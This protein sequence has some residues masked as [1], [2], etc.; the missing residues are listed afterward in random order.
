[1]EPEEQHCIPIFGIMAIKAGADLMSNDVIQATKIWHLGMFYNYDVQT[2]II[3]L[4]NLSGL[5]SMPEYL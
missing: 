4:L 2:P 5:L 3:L 1:M